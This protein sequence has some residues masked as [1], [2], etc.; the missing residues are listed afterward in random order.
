MGNEATVLMRIV[1]HC[2]IMTMIMMVVGCQQND[3]KNTSPVGP[4]PTSSQKSQSDTIAENLVDSQKKTLVAS[5]DSLVF[6]FQ[7]FV[8][9]SAERGRAAE[10]LVSNGFE[11]DIE[12]VQLRLEYL[13]QNEKRIGG[14]G[15]GA[16][17]SDSWCKA[18]ATIIFVAG[19]SI[20]EKVKKVRVKVK[21]IKF[22]DGTK[23]S[24]D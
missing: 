7:G 12:S 9:P 15:W 2:P 18:G 8:I 19:A 16:G 22:D 3:A 11:K 6:E 17:S 14:F 13:D 1:R 10:F 21:E 5:K 4:L 24:F 20:P 23:K